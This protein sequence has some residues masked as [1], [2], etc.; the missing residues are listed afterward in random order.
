MEKEQ[1]TTH[2][3]Y[4][5]HCPR[6]TYVSNT[7]L[8][9]PADL[10]NISTLLEGDPNMSNNMNSLISKIIQDKRRFK[11]KHSTTDNGRDDA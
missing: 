7:M 2:E 6:F 10:L 8:K 5:P 11:L 1:K 4:I 9:V 3:H